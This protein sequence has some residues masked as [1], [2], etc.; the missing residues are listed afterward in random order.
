MKSRCKSSSRNQR[1]V[2]N[3]MKKKVTKRSNKTICHQKKKLSQRKS[4]KS[5]KMSPAA[6]RANL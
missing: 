3:Q 1:A 2:T 6:R 4:P 5:M